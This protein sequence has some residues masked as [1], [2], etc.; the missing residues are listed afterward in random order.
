[1]LCWHV[2]LELEPLSPHRNGTSIP[3][4]NHVRGHNMYTVHLFSM[5]P[6]RISWNGGDDMLLF[7]DK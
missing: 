1:M 6:H 2:P 3:V 7:P 5:S 4:M